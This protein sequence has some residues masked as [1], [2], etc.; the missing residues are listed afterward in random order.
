MRVEA[1]APTEA[2]KR[3]VKS[4]SHSPI[5]LSPLQLRVCGSGRGLDAVADDLVP[6]PDV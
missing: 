3:H 6:G 1:S 5:D 4:R 2:I